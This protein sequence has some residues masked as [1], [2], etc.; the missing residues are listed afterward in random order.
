MTTTNFPTIATTY[1]VQ[2]TRTATYSDSRN[3]ASIVVSSTGN[4]SVGQRYK[5]SAPNIGYYLW[6]VFWAFDTS[7]IGT[8]VVSQVNL[9]LV[10]ANDY[11]DADFD[12]EIVKC[13]WSDTDPITTGN[14]DTAF[15]NALNSDLDS[16]IW[17]NTSGMSN[18]TQYT[19]G[20]LSTAWI[21]RTGT[22]YYA[23]RSG[24][25]SANSAP[26]GQEYIQVYQN[27]S[28]TEAYRP[29]LIVTYAAGGGGAISIAAQQ[30]YYARM[31]H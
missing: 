26:T 24:E 14:M 29:V 25:D 1:H 4:A 12:I 8:D 27:N 3:T 16:A 2:G 5:A 28:A 10:C 30:A 21:N 6:R 17:R 9:R 31:R 11:S 7:A 13:D 15:D 23:L 18:N 20:N 19:S 22:T